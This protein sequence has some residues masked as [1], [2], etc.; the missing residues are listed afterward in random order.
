MMN[1]KIVLASN[2]NHKLLEISEMLK[3]LG[4]TVISQS[5]AGI[6]LD[7]EETGTTFEENSLLKARAIYGVCKTAVIADDSGLEVDYLNK[8]PGVY[9]SRY[10]GENA[11][12]KEKCAKLLRELEGVP[13]KNRTAR[14]VSVICYID[15]NGKENIVRG[16]CE[17]YIGIEPQGKNG[18]GYDPIFMY[19]DKTFAEISAEEKNSISHRANALKKFVEL[20]E[21]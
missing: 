21:K 7:V 11:T 16:E 10:A 4:Y 1:N 20:L 2:N 13:K 6:S 3:P 5:Q 14:F 8:A 9:S 17:G 18:F 12:D 15:E 19:G